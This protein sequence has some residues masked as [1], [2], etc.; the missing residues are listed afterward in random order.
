V[1]GF[2]AWVSR[3]AG[4]EEGVATWQP[5]AAS[6][7]VVVVTAPHPGLLPQP[8]V[9]EFISIPS[10]TDGLTVV[11]ASL[12]FESIPQ[13]NKE[14]KKYEPPVPTRVGKKKKRGPAAA[15]KLPAGTFLHIL[16]RAC[17]LCGGN[18]FR[19]RY[20]FEHSG[21]GHGQGNLEARSAFDGG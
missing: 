14:K 19:S 10:E 4:F 13:Q 20:H 21:S 16:P 1:R 6:H 9:R 3:E 15:H 7:R 18:P 5:V 12:A 17:G 11:W 2:R 8:S